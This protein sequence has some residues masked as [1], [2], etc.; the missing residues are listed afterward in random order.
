M[1][2]L[3]RQ[4]FSSKAVSILSQFDATAETLKFVAEDGPLE[5]EIRTFLVS[6]AG[7]LKRD[8]KI[9]NWKHDVIT[10]GVDDD[11]AGYTYIRFFPKQWELPK[12][13]PVA[14]G[15]YWANPFLEDAEDLCVY[16]RIPWNWVHAD[17]LRELVLA[18]IPEG[19]TN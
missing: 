3:Q 6:V 18:R 2:K 9:Q 8:C 12:V 13:G 4:L 16:L 1:E 17:E 10:A 7:M 19:F 15:V 11:D 5:K 14:F